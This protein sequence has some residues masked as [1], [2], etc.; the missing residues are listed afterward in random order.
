MFPN[1][2]AIGFLRQYNFDGLDLDWEYPTTRDG[3]RQEDRNNYAIFVK[4]NLK[5]LL[6]GETVLS[7][8]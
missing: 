7:F 5:K 8:S 3:G 1:R 2:S 4:V 6:Q